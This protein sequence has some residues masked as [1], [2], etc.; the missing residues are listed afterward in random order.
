MLRAVI[1]DFDGVVVD[2]ERIHCTLMQTILHPLGIHL[3]EAEY[4][5]HYV[6]LTDRAAIAAILRRHGI[7]PA[8]ELVDRLLAQKRAQYRT[9]ICRN[10]IPWVPGIREWLRTATAYRLCLAIASSSS[11]DTIDPV[12]R[13]LDVHVPWVAIVTPQD[14]LQGKPAPDLYA[15]AV[16]RV[17]AVQ[18][19][20]H[21][22][23]ILAVEDTPDGIRAARAAG[24]HVA[25]LTTT[26]PA[27]ALRAAD[28]IIGPDWTAFPWSNI[29]HS[30]RTSRRE[31][32][33]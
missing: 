29:M 19:E 26:F 9:W 23:E 10:P 15:A 22:S 28:W 8:T 5:A 4:Y 12:L 3:T 7:R 11:R 33:Q 20:V 27:A 6:A 16:E 17:R 13:R 32:V 24:L 1:L 2:N 21:R 18:P 30:P 14:G 25:A 31:D